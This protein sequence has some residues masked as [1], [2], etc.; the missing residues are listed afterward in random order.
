MENEEI[1]RLEGVLKSLKDLERDCGK[2]MNEEQL[3]DLLQKISKIEAQIEEVRS[4]TE[5]E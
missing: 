1:T 5:A 4:L 3:E 2:F